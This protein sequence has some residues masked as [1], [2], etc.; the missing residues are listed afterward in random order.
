[1]I[2]VYALSE[3]FTIKADTA[4]THPAI[5]NTMVALHA[6]D[7]FTLAGLTTTAPVGT[8]YLQRRIDSFRAG[9][10]KENMIQA[11]WG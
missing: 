5:V 1:M 2:G 3:Q 8:G 10:C 11:V 7:K 9:I 6:A 4:D